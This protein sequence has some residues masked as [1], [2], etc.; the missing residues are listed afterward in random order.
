MKSKDLQNAVFSKYRNGDGPTKIFHELSGE[1]SL[2][3]IKLWCKM[4]DTTGSINLAYSSDRL[5]ILRTPGA[6][7][8]VKTRADAKGGAQFKN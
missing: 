6:I 1:L 2:E 8:K 3:T 7:K 4:I 5:C